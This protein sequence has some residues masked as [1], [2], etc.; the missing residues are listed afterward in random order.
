EGIN[1]TGIP[2]ESAAVAWFASFA[3]FRKFCYLT[4][5]GT[6]TLGDRYPADTE[7]PTGAFNKQAVQNLPRQDDVFFGPDVNLPA[8]RATE[9]V[10]LDLGRGPQFLPDRLTGRRE[11]R[12]GRTSNQNP[13]DDRSFLFLRYCYH[14]I[15]SQAGKRCELYRCHRATSPF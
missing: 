3:A 4:G 2:L 15:F 13:F 12:C 9:P 6:H 7:R 10:V 11:F 5:P 8:V 1:A 14:K